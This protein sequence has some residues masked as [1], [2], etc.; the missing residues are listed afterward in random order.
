MS[1]QE[2]CESKVKNHPQSAGPPEARGRQIILG[3]IFGVVFGF[4]LQ[5]GGVGKYHVLIGMLLLEDFTVLQVM[6]T[7]VVVGMIGIYALH[8]AK[9]VELHIK[10]TRYG[11]NALGGLLFGAGFALAAYCPGTSAA[12]LGQGNYDAL[13]VILGMMAGSYVF[14]ESSGWIARTIDHWGDRG[15][16]TLDRLL[17]VRLAFLVPVLASLLVLLLVTVHF[18]DNTAE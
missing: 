11:A 8:A 16:L 3:L 13:A 18:V 12:A 4:L 6:L 10:P 17:G 7:A 1:E 2:I 5:K 14:A 15:K 9:L